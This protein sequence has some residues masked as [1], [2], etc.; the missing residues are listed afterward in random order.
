MR[1]LLTNDDGVRAEGIRAA[2]E[3]LSARHEV[4]VVAPSENRSAVSHGIT[5]ERNLEIEELGRNVWSCSGL[6][7]DCVLTALKTGLLPAPPDA[8]VSGINAGANIGTDLLYSGT[9]AA[10]RQAVIYGV[11]AVALSLEF[12]GPGP[13]LYGA[14]ARFA[15]E[16]METLASLSDVRHPAVF[17]NVNALSLPSY[18]DARLTDALSFRD[19]SDSVS[20]RREGGRTVSVFHGGVPVSETGA[21]FDFSVCADGAVAVSRVYAEPRPGPRVDGVRFL[22]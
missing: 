3:A 11:P 17:V 7:A 19:Y 20:L 22:L 2:A 5:M 18:H 16:N 6:P 15:S 14:L 10:A 21:G 1:I 9:A 8:V 13:L 4:Y 12:N